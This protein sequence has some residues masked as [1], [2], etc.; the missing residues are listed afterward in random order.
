MVEMFLKIEDTNLDAETEYGWKALDIATSSEYCNFGKILLEKYPRLTDLLKDVASN[1]V[2]LITVIDSSPIIEYLYSNDDCYETLK[3]FLLDNLNDA[4][5]YVLDYT[6]ANIN[7]PLEKGQTL[8][9]IA[10]NNFLQDTVELLIEKGQADPN[11]LDKNGKT[12][13]IWAVINEDLPMVKFLLEVGK[14]DINLAQDYSE[15]VLFLAVEANNTE[16]VEY[17]VTN[18]EV[19]F[20]NGRD[21]TPLYK[22]SILGYLPIVKLLLEKG[23]GCNGNLNNLN[24]VLYIATSQ[25]HLNILKYLIEDKHISPGTKTYYGATPLITALKTNQFDV[26]KYILSTGRSDVN[27]K[28]GRITAL[29]VRF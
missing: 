19:T 27:A 3:H 7:Q 28:Y 1:D 20:T 14:A 13:L 11:I 6:T 8:L 26:A 17:L 9:H 24:M 2:D 21:S 10:A 4:V 15:T 18:P 5:G 23:G 12:P 16:M 29:Q 22:A 25:G